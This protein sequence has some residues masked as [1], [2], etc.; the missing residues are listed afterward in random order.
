MPPLF[1]NV[2]EYKAVEK[3]LEELER[4]NYLLDDSALEMLAR[5][6]AAE[7]LKAL[8]E[9]EARMVAA[10]ARCPS[11]TLAGL[12]RDML[13]IKSQ[14]AELATDGVNPGLL[15][16]IA[17]L[18]TV[19]ALE[20]LQDLAELAYWLRWLR[21]IEEGMANMPPQRFWTE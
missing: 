21:R 17:K 19:E 12:V 5:L 8:Q 13:Y 10:D 16:C 1:C 11:L 4:A 9:F 14:L 20:A 2:Q 15:D 3:R 6:S 18:S 7:G